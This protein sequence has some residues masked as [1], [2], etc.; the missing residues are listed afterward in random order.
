MPDQEMPTRKTSPV[1][2]ASRLV[3]TILGWMLVLAVI[4]GVV[5]MLVRLVPVFLKLQPEV[6]AALI[7]TSGTVLVSV[8]SVLIAK[9]FER[10]AEV[11]REHITR[12]TEIYER[13]IEFWFGI[14]FANKLGE[15][16]PGE[17]ELMRFFHDTIK[18]FV[19]WG[20]DRVLRAFSRFRSLAAPPE[21]VE[22]A[23]AMLL[24]FEDM[25]FE[26]RKDLGHSNSGLAKGDILGMFLKDY[27]STVGKQLAGQRAGRTRR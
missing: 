20:G 11:R 12:K 10:K 9:R 19:T 3:P 16:Q 22:D 18:D 27:Q 17:Q 7:V 15:K 2:L 23:M 13:H 24:A 25:L 21:K 14:L 8:L 6:V 5:Y 26:I 4:S 1:H